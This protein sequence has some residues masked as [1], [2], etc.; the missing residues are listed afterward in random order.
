MEKKVFERSGKKAALYRSEQ[1]DRPLVILNSYAGGG[2]SVLEAMRPIDVP[3]CNLLVIGDLEWDHDMTPWYCPP[4]TGQ[5][6]P[7]TGGADAYLELMLT[8]IVPKAEEMING[9]PSFV[10]IAGYSLAGLF[11]LYSAYRCGAFDRIAS[12]SGSLWFPDFR[13]Y[14]LTHEIQKRP[15]KMYFSLGDREAHTRNSVLMT[16][17]KNTEEL[18]DHYK[19]LG[20]EVTWELNP[21]NHFKDAALRSAKGIKAILE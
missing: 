13:E 6:T 15:A 5:D 19:S 2:E 7:F 10:G 3:E 12:M 18:V 4:L 1:A 8:Q 17:Q 21:G 16:V 9:T 14:A 11:A 20:L